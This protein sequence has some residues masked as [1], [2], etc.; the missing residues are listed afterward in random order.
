MLKVAERAEGGTGVQTWVCLSA[1]QTCTGPP[2]TRAE[3]PFVAVEPH[4]FPA[5]RVED[6][7]RA[8]G[9]RPA[10]GTAAGGVRQVCT[11]LWGNGVSGPD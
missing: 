11:S 1:E 7:R 8:G 4:W 3:R 9:P 2:G 10:L 5:E 6:V